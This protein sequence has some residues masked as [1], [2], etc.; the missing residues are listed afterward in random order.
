MTRFYVAVQVRGGTATAAA[1]TEAEA[2]V[3]VEAEQA[4]G[5]GRAV[6]SSCARENGQEVEHPARS[7]P[8]PRNSS[9][10]SKP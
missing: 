9:S 8:C 3:E 2:E 6:A 7:R 10:S 4:D 5:E 1:T